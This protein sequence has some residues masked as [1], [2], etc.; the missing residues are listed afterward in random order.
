M[1][2]CT[3]WLEMSQKNKPQ[4]NTLSAG[5][6][7]LMTTGFVIGSSIFNMDFHSQ[8][9]TFHHSDSTVLLATLSFYIAAMIGSVVGYLLV[10]RYEK[11]PI[12]KVYLCLVIVASILMIA[13]PQH[14]VGVTFARV[15][16]GLAHGSAYLVV[17][18][19]GGEVAIKEMRGMNMSAVHYC[20]TVGVLSHGSFS[21][22]A[23]FGQAIEPNRI[24][25][26]IGLT[27]AVLGGGLAQFLTYE[28]PVYLIQR[29]RDAEAITTMMKL[30]QES[31]ETWD[32]R[33]DYT[34]FKAMLQE[35]DESSRSTFR[36]GNLR[37]LALLSL[38]KLASVLSFNVALNLVRLYTL[39]KLFGMENYSL[40]ATMILTIRLIAGV[41]FFYTIDAFGRRVPMAMSSFASGA[42]LTIF[43]IVFL[44]AESINR[45]VGIAIMLTYDVVASAGV[46]FVPDVYCSE[47]FS[48]QKKAAS[49]AAVQT[50][51]NILQITIIAVF[52]SWDL[53]NESYYAGITLACG[54]PLIA[55]A[56][57]FYR[58]LPETAKMSIRQSRTEFSKRGEIVFR[59]TK[60]PRNY[61]ND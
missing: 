25:G 33:N 11:K 59:G 46:T 10:E 26:I 44:C 5:I 8:S 45:D 7:T 13:L 34:E 21:P 61:L 15:L 3:E 2:G 29:G 17:L 42:F 4:S 57:V 39:D 52:F 24:I 31:T 23:T 41:L 14:I 54:I 58:Y 20:L 30:R 27:C 6:M 37:P 43:G 47:A 51:E 49:I 36:D 22:T 1:G 60:Q 40:S 53:T 48:T 32:I 38:G 19:H 12:S 35:D 9:W 55:L 56:V 50:V 28:S 18:I 16:F